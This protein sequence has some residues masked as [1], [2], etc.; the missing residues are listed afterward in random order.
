[1]YYNINGDKMDEIIVPMIDFAVEFLKNNGIVAGFFLVIL[2]SIIPILPLGLF[3]AMNFSA[4]GYVFGFLISYIATVTGC[5]MS[6]IFAKYM[7]SLY[8]KKGKKTKDSFN[9]I[10]NKI[11]KIDFSHLVLIMALPFSP[12]F[13]INIA[14]G[15][16]KIN[17]KKF[18]S[19]LLISKISIIY[20]WGLVG[21][22]LI[23]SIGDIKTIIII[24][25]S[26]VLS[27]LLSKIVS[28][29]MN[30]E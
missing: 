26:L 2:E 19:A 14:A 6:F 12:A 7:I 11:Q 5:I 9:K 1:M 3:V 28:K 25:L 10:S 17:F 8:V 16:C 30:L 13:F 27:Y 21:K 22:S 15:V 20:F 4:Y 29:K 23:D 24:L 18:L